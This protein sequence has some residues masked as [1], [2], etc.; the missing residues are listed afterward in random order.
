MRRYDNL[1]AIGAAT[2]QAR[3]QARA[4]LASAT[5][6][7]RGMQAAVDQ[8]RASTGR[9]EEIQAQMAGAAGSN[10]ALTAAQWRLSQRHF[11]AVT[12]GVVA[13]VLA[14]PGETIQAGS[15]VVSL[16]PPGNIFI[17]FFIPEP[18]LGQVHRGDRL[19]FACDGCKDGLEGTVEY[20]SPQ[21]EYTPPLIY[22]DQSRA[23]LIYMVQA[24]P[25]ADQAL[26]FNPGQP[27]T[28]RPVDAAAK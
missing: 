1:A 26:L 4:D 11:K 25:R 14:R 3:D 19:T 28:V 20:I 8:L 12:G 16:M 5:A 21:A 27:V 17:R 22:S 24:R 18:M 13:D 23:K 6:K 9:P 10:A 15:P 7:V 2:D